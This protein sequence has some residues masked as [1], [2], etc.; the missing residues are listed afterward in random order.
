MEGFGG[1]RGRWGLGRKKG[2]GG[3]FG[4]LI[5]SSKRE[6]GWKTENGGGQGK[7]VGH[8]LQLERYKGQDRN[9]GS[10]RGWGIH[11]F[12]RKWGEE[13]KG[14]RRVEGGGMV[15]LGK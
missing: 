12:E 10:E 11:K 1:E 8:E 2:K 3:Y 9:Q 6:G 7:E 14:G 15:V 4:G 5:V 13:R